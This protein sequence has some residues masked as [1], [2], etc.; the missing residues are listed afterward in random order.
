MYFFIDFALS[1]LKGLPFFT[2]YYWSK[3]LYILFHS[4]TFPILLYH[5]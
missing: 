2:L 5:C 4:K 1:R 3:I